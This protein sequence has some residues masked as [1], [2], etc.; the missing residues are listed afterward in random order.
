MMRQ[1]R[2]LA[3]V[4]Y[5][6]VAAEHAASLKSQSLDALGLFPGATVLDVG[7][8][9][10]TDIHALA[11]AKAYRVVGVDID[12]PMRGAARMGTAPGTSATFICAEAWRLLVM[13][14]I[15][16]AVRSEGMLQND[17]DPAGAVFEATRVIR[18]SS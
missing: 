18:P 12:L 10:G 4:G 16:V 1:R 5:L 11:A 17:A 2:Q 15:V 8:G 7:C 9:P 3:D 14:M 13:D 6:Q